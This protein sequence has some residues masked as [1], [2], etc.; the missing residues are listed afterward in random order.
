M[1]R[2]EGEEWEER[3]GVAGRRDFGIRK[4][5]DRNRKKRMNRGEWMGINTI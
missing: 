4:E 3:E 1:G 2:W 5:D